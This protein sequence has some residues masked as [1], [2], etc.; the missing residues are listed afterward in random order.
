MTKS[1]FSADLRVIG[2]VASKGDLDV[3]G[4][5]EGTVSVRALAVARDAVI[6]GTVRAVSVEIAGRIAG[7]LEC[8]HVAIESM[9]S[10]DG[11]VAYRTLSVVPGGGL[12][13]RCA[14]IPGDRAV[15]AASGADTT[16][17]RADSPTLARAANRPMANVPA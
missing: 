5:I 11:D 14:P 12:N 4:S 15:T 16:G 2:D 8:D 17:G 10:L 6:E 9:G 1:V 13:A 3:H 7:R